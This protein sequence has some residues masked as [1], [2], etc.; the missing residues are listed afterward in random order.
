MFL[1]TSDGSPFIENDAF[2]E[3]VSSVRE[4]L[5]VAHILSDN[6]WPVLFVCGAEH[7]V[8]VRRLFH[9]IGVQSEIVHLDYDP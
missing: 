2:N 9:Q 6:E 1:D 4:R 8:P 7:T 5:F 3:L